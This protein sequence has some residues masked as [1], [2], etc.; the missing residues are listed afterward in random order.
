VQAREL[1][2]EG[3]RPDGRLEADALE[4]HR[5]LAGDGGT[6]GEG[7]GLESEEAQRLALSHEGQDGQA[8]GF[9]ASPEVPAPDRACLDE[10]LAGRPG[11]VR[12]RERE[13]P[14]PRNQVGPLGLVEREAQRLHAEGR[15]VLGEEG[16]D[17][18]LVL[19]G[20]QRH[21][22]GAHEV[23]LAGVVEAAPRVLSIG[24]LAQRDAG[25]VKQLLRGLERLWVQ[26]V[27]D[28]APQAGQGRVPPLGPVASG[29]DAL[30]ELHEG[31]LEGA[32]R[33]LAR[34]LREAGLEAL[35]Q[36]GH[37]GGRQLRARAVESPDHGRGRVRR[38]LLGRRAGRVRVPVETAA[39]TPPDELRG[40]GD[41]VR[42]ARPAADEADEHLDR[43]P[44]G[45]GQRV[46]DRGER[47]DVRR[48]ARLVVEADDR[49]VLGH[50]PAGVGEGAHGADCRGVV[51]RE[52]RGEPPPGRQDPAHGLETALLAVEA[53][54]DEVLAL[55]E[56]ELAAQAAEVGEPLH[57]VAEVQRV[58]GHEC[59]G[60]VPVR[61]QVKESLPKAGGAVGDHGREAVPGPDEGD[62][63]AGPLQAE[64]VASARLRAQRRNEDEAV[65]VPGP[66]R[67]E[68]ALVARDGPAG[69]HVGRIVDPGV[70]AAR[71]QH[72]AA[73][74]GARLGHSA[75]N[76]FEE[77]VGSRPLV[78][79]PA[80]HDAD[81]RPGVR[82]GHF[83]ARHARDR[84][85]AGLAS[86]GHA[87]R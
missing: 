39:G 18:S 78:H 12:R 25:Q 75:K 71:E 86:Q 64:G 59:D 3:Q 4:G 21:G 67:H 28:G 61:S 14:G 32:G 47:R 80:R 79:L 83:V 11:T 73:E 51:A 53:V 20:L 33:T 17:L 24:A 35:A 48:S 50:A 76:G 10:E 23:H 16:Q 34:A 38:R 26:S 72:V 68:V 82:P 70:D 52:D 49:H 31:G 45:F 27:A 58:A 60:A 43:A 57:A 5:E 1:V 36:A 77:P 55:V 56:A 30:E 40:D 15:G 19:G 13:H 9:G 22:E 66:H 2:G 46:A 63:E 44:A 85:G 65:G 29:F 37:G 42:R 41:G 81:R 87:S 6:G 74:G 84:A 54:G 7:G 62:G 69:A 8:A